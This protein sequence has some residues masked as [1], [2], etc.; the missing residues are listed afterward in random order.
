MKPLPILVCVMLL[1]ANPAYA[2][3]WRFISG[4]LGPPS[5]IVVGDAESIRPTGTHSRRMWIETVYSHAGDDGIGD[6]LELVEFDCT[7]LRQ[8]RLS[9]VAHADQGA[10]VGTDDQITPWT[11]IPPATGAAAIANA[12]CRGFPATSFALANPV[13]DGRRLM[14]QVARGEPT[15]PVADALWQRL[16]DQSAPLRR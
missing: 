6:K 4:Q 13:T 3:A 9:A 8:R 15:S 5:T 7:D 10:V 11:F 16:Q 12:A 2:S 1:V 14:E